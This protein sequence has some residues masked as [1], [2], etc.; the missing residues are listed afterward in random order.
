[1]LGVGTESAAGA[2]RLKEVILQKAVIDSEE[3]AS[4][5]GVRGTHPPGNCF[6]R[7]FDGEIVWQNSEQFLGETG[8]ETLGVGVLF[9]VREGLPLKIPADVGDAPFVPASAS[10]VPAEDMH[11]HRVE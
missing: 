5:E 3:P 2:V 9:V 6:G 10:G 11:G 7:N 8:E 1:M 4:S